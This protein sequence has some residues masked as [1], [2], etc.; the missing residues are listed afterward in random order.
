M[1]VFRCFFCP[2]YD[3]F[4]VIHEVLRDLKKSGPTDFV[5]ENFFLVF[6]ENNSVFQ[7]HCYY[8][9]Y[10]YKRRVKIKHKI[11]KRKINI[12]NKDFFFPT[13]KKLV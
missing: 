8:K 10:T 2:C 13:D 12:K 9:K 3:C 6:N 5:N 11:Y 1:F 4:I 7:K